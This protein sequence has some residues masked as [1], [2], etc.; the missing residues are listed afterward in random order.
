MIFEIKNK[1]LTILLKGYYGFGN[2]GDDLLMQINYQILKEAC[3]NSEIDIFSNNTHSNENS[4][5]DT[6][7]HLYTQKLINYPLDIVDWTHKKRYDLIG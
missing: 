2:L 1:K 7:Y 6:N 5:A 3:P 4:I